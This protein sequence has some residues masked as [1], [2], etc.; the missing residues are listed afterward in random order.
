MKLF[1]TSEIENVG[2]SGS[3]DKG[4]SFCAGDSVNSN[5]APVS[6]WA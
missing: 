3:D 2:I 6:V 1:T 5:S 4:F